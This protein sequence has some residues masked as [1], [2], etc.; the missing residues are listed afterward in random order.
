MSKQKDKPSRAPRLRLLPFLIFATGLMFTVKLGGI[1]EGVSSIRHGVSVEPIKAQAQQPPAPAPTAAPR[2]APPQQ[3]A[4]TGDGGQSDGNPEAALFT[5]TEIDVLQK[6]A[7]RRE[8]LEGRSRELDA[9]EALLNA[10]EERIDGKI[11]EIKNLENTIHKLISQYNTLEDNKLKSLVNIY[12]KMKPRDAARIFNELEMPTLIAVIERMKDTKTAP[13][14]AEMDSVKA[15]A[16]TS[17]LAHRNR[18]PAPENVAG[19]G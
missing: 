6:L 16:L 7:E 15:K 17:E 12:E 1:W 14:M 4:S 13:I 10:A 3:R 5:Q 18:L 8:E 9:R 2:P 11:S 19:G